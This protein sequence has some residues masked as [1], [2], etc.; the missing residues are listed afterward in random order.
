MITQQTIINKT[1]PC[2]CGCQGQDPWHRRTYQR[3]VMQTSDT[4][5]IV[6]LPYSTQRVEVVREAH[7]SARNILVYGP[8]IVDRESIIW[9]K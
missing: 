9:D 5:G 2:N 3:T 8:W 1:S 4:T 6:R 7:I